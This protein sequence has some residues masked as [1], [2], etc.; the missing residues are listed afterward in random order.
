MVS[1]R[2]FE[3]MLGLSSVEFCLYDISQE[4]GA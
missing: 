1:G 3:Y 2:M 4:A